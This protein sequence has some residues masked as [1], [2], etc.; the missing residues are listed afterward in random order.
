MKMSLPQSLRGLLALAALSLCSPA[1]EPLPEPP[2]PPQEIRA[3]IANCSLEQDY[4]AAEVQQPEHELSRLGELAPFAFDP[5]SPMPEAPA[6]H[7]AVVADGGLLYDQARS[8]LSY[9]GNVRLNDENLKLRAAYRLYVRLPEHG[10]GSE[11][12]GKEPAAA[13]KPQAAATTPAVKK[14]ASP[15]AGKAAPPAAGKS[16]APQERKPVEPLPPAYVTA[17]NAA[18]DMV[19]SRFLLEGRRS[20]PSLT[21]TRGGDSV[22]MERAA[23]G[24]AAKMFAAARG[25][26]LMQGRDITFI[27]QDAEGGRWQ[28]SVAEGPVYYHAARRCLVA[29]GTSRLISPR[30]T[31]RA[32]RA[33]YIVFSEQ[34]AA[35]SSGSRQPFIRF[36]GLRFEGVDHVL[37]FGSVELTAAAE[38]GAGESSTLRG[39]ALRFEAAGG[40]CRVYGSP[41]SLEYGAN[42][43]EAPG[44]I[45]LQGNGDIVISSATVTGAYERPFESEPAPP[46]KRRAP[47]T[48]RGTYRAPG[49]ITYNAERNCITM[50]RG[51]SARDAHGAFSCTG[52]LTAHLS[53]RPGARAPKPPRPGMSMPNLAIARQGSVSRITAEGHVHLHSDASATT[54]A[55]RVECDA[56]ESDLAIG[57]ASL[58]ATRGRRAYL[59]YGA[60]LLTAQTPQEGDAMV[61]LLGNGDLRISAAAIHATL[62]GDAG[63]TRVDC[64]ESLVLQR[65]ESLLTLGPES[66]ICSPSGLLTARAPLR[67]FLAEGEPPATPPAHAG[68]YPQLSYN[69]SGLRRVETPGGGT[70]R[71]PQ[72]SLEC[73]GSI[74]LELKTGA[75]LQ[76]GADA[77]SAI[78]HAAAR[79]NVQVAGRDADGR[80]MRAVGDRLDFEPST[81]NFCLRGRSV[82]LVDAYNSHTA[83]GR[84]ACITIDPENNVQIDGENHVTTASQLQQQIDK[85]K[86]SKK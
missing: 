19:D 18:L 57:T 63:P 82:T 29:P 67:A 43:M 12:A 8:S 48:I 60:Y 61:Y 78:R 86:N 10:T 25:D 71:T 45:T 1:E 37:A 9:L 85:E 83:T 23:N 39:D 2:V 62:P 44:T 69:Y 46:G 80:L 26:I 59:R 11:P 42:T 28:L 31:M 58:R 70:V 73:E 79:G 65:A 24:A 41:C 4:F 35:P 13:E 55:Y 75:Q 49:P 27:W 53:P 51:I 81:G 64:T 84:G 22:R 17:E 56:M 14:S 50:P 40:E 21:I 32:Q 5:A 15:P 72:A 54:P 74:S 77:R 20:S 52:A 30:Y 7:S 47:A 34:Q 36:T 33:L 66:R 76:G 3:A 16:A 38:S 68:K 6:G